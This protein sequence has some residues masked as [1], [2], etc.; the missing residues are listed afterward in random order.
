MR[1]PSGHPLRLSS[2]Q[3]RTRPD[4]CPHPRHRKT[5]AVT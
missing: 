5:W 4:N 1:D 2:C 3:A